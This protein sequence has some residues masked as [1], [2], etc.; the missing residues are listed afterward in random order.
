MLDSK[1]LKKLKEV[2]FE[3]EHLFDKQQKLKVVINTSL[4]NSVTN[5]IF[6][7]FNYVIRVPEPSLSRYFNRSAEINNIK[8]TYKQLEMTNEPVYFNVET[9]VMASRYTS[10]EIYYEKKF[11]NFDTTDSVVQSMNRFNGSGLQLQE[12]F[13]FNDALALFRTKKL[14]SEKNI[15]WLIDYYN[16]NFLQAEILEPSHNDPDIT[17]FTVTGQI[18]DFEYSG[19]SPQLSDIS[20][21]YSMYFYNTEVDGYIRNL[22]LP[23]ELLQ[24]QVI[25]WTFFWSMWALSKDKNIVKN[26]NYLKNARRNLIFANELLTYHREK[27]R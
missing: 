7:M 18:I 16:R 12:C 11:L 15:T 6:K 26:H 17:N 13:D 4:L 20:N 5:T 19:M 10:P 23:Q 27:L 14:T 8:E 9:G 25:F 3:V 1:D 22:E 21:F 2:F 24:P